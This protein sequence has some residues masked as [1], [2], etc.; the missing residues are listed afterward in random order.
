[1][2]PSD[3]MFFMAVT[4][5]HVDNINKGPNQPCPPCPRPLGFLALCGN[6][7]I[8]TRA[9]DLI[10]KLHGP[11][12]IHGVLWHPLCPVIRQDRVRQILEGIE[13]AATVDQPAIGF[14]SKLTVQLVRPPDLTCCRDLKFCPVLLWRWPPPS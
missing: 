2:F 4:L 11:L 12:Q 8:A 5:L 10:P 3:F 6:S 7:L 14:A 1:M 9:G 13:E